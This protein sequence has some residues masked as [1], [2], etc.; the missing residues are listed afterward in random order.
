[1]G[2][3]GGA[4]THRLVER[5][6][7]TAIRF[8]LIFI[9]SL[10]WDRSLPLFAFCDGHAMEN[11]YFYQPLPDA[12][13]H[14]RLLRIL[15]ARKGRTVR[16]E[17]SVWPRHKAPDYT[18]VSYTWG[19]PNSITPIVLDETQKLVRTNCEYVL[20]QAFNYKSRRYYWVDALCINQDDL[21]EKAKQVIVMGDIFKA[22]KLVLCCIGEHADGSDGLFEVLRRRATSLRSMFDENGSTYVKG[23]RRRSI[24]G[25]VCYWSWSATGMRQDLATITSAAV[26][27]SQRAYFSRAW[28]VQEVALAKRVRLCC[29]MDSSPSLAWVDLVYSHC[30]GQEIEVKYWLQPFSRLCSAISSRNSSQTQTLP[31][32]YVTPEDLIQLTSFTNLA[33]SEEMSSSPLEQTVKLMEGKQCTDVRDRIF[34]SLKL[35]GWDN[36]PP[37]TPNYK[38]SAF[39]L[40]VDVLARLLISKRVIRYHT[41]S[42]LLRLLRLKPGD[43]IPNE[44]FQDTTPDHS[45]GDFV[46]VYG[47]PLTDDILSN[48]HKWLLDVLVPL[49]EVQVPDG[50]LADGRVAFVRSSTAAGA[51]EID[52]GHDW[53]LAFDLDCTCFGLIVRRSAENLYIVVGCLLS[54]VRLSILNVT[55]QFVLYAQPS[56]LL[57]WAIVHDA[58]E[59]GVDRTGGADDLANLIDRIEIF[60]NAT[61]AFA[62]RGTE[63]EVIEGGILRRVRESRF[64]VPD[65]VIPHFDGEARWPNE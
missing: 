27:L 17:V 3:C 37:I 12:G 22:A 53:V 35:I 47:F 26:D 44:R 52:A 56:D 19:D 61:S 14:I 48:A 25:T 29:G 20:R 8:V 40:G 51:A 28:V 36:Q 65:F 11:Q 59:Q 30:Y 45:P 63:N 10:I 50:Q 39:D 4:A 42:E 32:P 13:T 33:G 6:R 1:M 62:I 46:N 2:L 7:Q 31:I 43:L 9:S 54:S 5:Q 49:A 57:A 23:S 24:T 38:I 55:R 34:A 21:D 18:A 15:E 58:A 60:R 41:F 64:K 16:C